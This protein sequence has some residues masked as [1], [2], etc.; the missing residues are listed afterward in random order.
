MRVEP[1][2]LPL[3]E[4]QPSG[5]LPGCVRHADAAEVVRER[6]PP[7]ECHGS[8]RQSETPG[9]GLREIGYTRRVLAKPRRLETG[10]RGDGREGGIDLLTCD[11]D[12]RERLD[13]EHL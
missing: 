4:A 11:P 7:H 13:L 5:F 12:L 8:F 10:E 3:S 2:P 6:G 1:H 9:R